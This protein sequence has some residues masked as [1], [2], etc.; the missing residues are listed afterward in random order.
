MKKR[1]F[2]FFLFPSQ[3]KCFIFQNLPNR[4]NRM[5]SVGTVPDNSILLPS[6]NS[7]NR[8]KLAIS[9]GNVPVNMLLPTCNDRN[10]DTLPI[11]VGIVPVNALRCNHNSL[12]PRLSTCVGIVP[13]KTL[14]YRRIT[15]EFGGREIC[16]K[17]R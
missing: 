9:V 14:K 2:F 10:N 13:V 8:F 7:T 16:W 12:V 15:P 17:S 6:N 11:S 5:Y 3:P 1:T 4:F